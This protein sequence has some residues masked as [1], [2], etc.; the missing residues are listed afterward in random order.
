MQQLG[1][2]SI[3]LQLSI[4]QWELG[5]GEEIYMQEPSGYKSGRVASVKQLVKMLY[6]LKQAGHK[7]YNTLHIMLTDLGLHIT[8]VDLA[9]FIA[10]IQKNMLILVAHVDNCVITG[11]SMELIIKYRAKLNE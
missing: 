7:W 9:V 10:R 8:R 3:Q 2:K 4:P 1:H 5:K 11:S 6:N